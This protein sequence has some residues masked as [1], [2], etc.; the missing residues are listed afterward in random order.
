MSPE[1]SG[2]N[3]PGRLEKLGLQTI[4]QHQS[5]CG[6]HTFDPA[7][8][9]YRSN[10][11]PLPIFITFEGID[12]S[13]KTT[14]LHRLADYAR[15]T[16]DV[17]VITTREPGGS[18]V[19]RLIRDILLG[20][21]GRDTEIDP[22]TQVMLFAADRVAHMEHVIK[23][24]LQSGAWVFCDRWEDST[25]AYQGAGNQ[26]TTSAEDADYVE[27]LITMARR[28]ILPDAT[29]LLDIPAELSAARVTGRGA[30]KDRFEQQD[31]TFRQRVRD[32]YLQLHADPQRQNSWPMYR[33][34]AQP[35]IDAIHHAL[36]YGLDQVIDQHLTTP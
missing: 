36:R 25:R 1:H 3:N 14:Q 9:S 24:A 15:H 31:L 33:V 35:S 10:K 17:E 34:D 32:A 8:M 30:T 11:Q 28:D 4:K 19:G 5:V 7:A 26:L 6:D 16:Y 22:Y 13:G 18:A 12:G 23:P 27:S 21:T 29:F 20:D 2:A